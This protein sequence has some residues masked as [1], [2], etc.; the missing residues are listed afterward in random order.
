MHSAI[1]DSER[2]AVPSKENYQALFN[3]AA[4]PYDRFEEPQPKAPVAQYASFP[5]PSE[6]PGYDKLAAAVNPGYATFPEYDELSAVKGP[7]YT[8][9]FPD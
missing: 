7:N 9:A 4:S 1:G 5:P 2:R 8:S 6:G 3:A